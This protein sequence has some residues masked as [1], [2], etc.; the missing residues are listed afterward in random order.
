M[1]RFAMF[2]NLKTF[3]IA[4]LAPV[5]AATEPIKNLLLA[6]TVLYVLN[7]IIGVVEDIYN[8]KDPPKIKKLSIS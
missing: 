1:K 4:L 5:V 3:I 2:E 6:V 8:K 7:L